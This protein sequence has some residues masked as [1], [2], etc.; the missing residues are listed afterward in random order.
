MAILKA[1]CRLRPSNTC[2]AQG[3]WESQC[4]YKTLSK[5][6]QTSTSLHSWHCN[7][8]GSSQ[9][10][11]HCHKPQ[12]IRCSPLLLQLLTVL[13]WRCLD[14]LLLSDK[15][16]GGAATQGLAGRTWAAEG[17]APGA[18]AASCCSEPVLAAGD[19]SSWVL[20]GCQLPAAGLTLGHTAPDC[21]ESV[22]GA[23]G[24]PDPAMYPVVEGRL[25]VRLTHCETAPELLAAWSPG[26]TKLL[27]ARAGSTTGRC[28][29][30]VYTLPTS[31]CRVC[32]GLRQ[33]CKL[34]EEA[35]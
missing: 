10:T 9:Q 27:E 25:R 30:Q 1:D 11:P 17:L 31:C 28:L 14:A 21:A 6:S 8:L 29:T 22:R 26:T 23:A 18:P 34:P 7:T 5:T 3:P 12:C 32:P 4:C 24:V 15:M 16:G 20:L 33:G 2:D 19:P 13:L 35:A